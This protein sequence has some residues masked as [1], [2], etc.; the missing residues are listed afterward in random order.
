MKSNQLKK[1]KNFP[2]VELSFCAFSIRT[3]QDTVKLCKVLEL[4]SQ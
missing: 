4:L 2:I 3:E 1:D